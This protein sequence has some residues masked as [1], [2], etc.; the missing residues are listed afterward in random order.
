MGTRYNLV[1][2]R[3]IVNLLSA[4]YTDQKIGKIFWDS[5]PVS[6]KSGTLTNRMQYKPLQGKVFAKTGSMRDVSS[7]SGY[8]INANGKF[9]T[10]SIIANNINANTSMNNGKIFEEKVL[11]YL[12]DNTYQSNLLVQSFE[13][14]ARRQGAIY[15]YLNG[16]LANL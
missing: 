15:L 14:A 12:Y 8:M 6:G 4:M 3:Q 7:L 9:I 1:T 16:R 13:Q 11:D 5:L 2:S 10:F